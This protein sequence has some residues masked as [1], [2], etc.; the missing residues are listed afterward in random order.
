[1]G[2]TLIK[3]PIYNKFLKTAL[4]ISFDFFQKLLFQNLSGPNFGLEK[5]KYHTIS[6]ILMEDLTKTSY[7]IYVQSIVKLSFFQ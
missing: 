7:Y 4:V 6:Y 3:Q 1:M 2:V 5:S